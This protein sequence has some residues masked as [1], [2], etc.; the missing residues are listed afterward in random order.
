MEIAS[1]TPSASS[2]GWESDGEAEINPLPLVWEGKT[3][4]DIHNIFLEA[5]RQI[6]D[7]QTNNSEE[8]LNIAITGYEYLLGPIHEETVKVSFTLATFFVEQNR[9]PEAYKVIERSSRL[10]FEQLGIDHKRTQQH[11]MNVV[12][13][14]NGWN[15]NDDALAFLGRAKELAEGNDKPAGRKT[16]RRGQ[17]VPKQLAATQQTLLESAIRSVSNASNLDQLDYGLSIARTHASTKDEAVE[18][19]LLE[20]I[21]QSGLNIEKAALQ[22]IQAWAELL[23]VERTE[24]RSQ[25]NL[26]RF[27]YA[28]QAFKKVVDQFPW[29]Q[30]TREKFKSQKLIE[31]CLEL[32]ATFVK[33]DFLDDAR[34]IFQKCD[35][36]ATEAFGSDDERTIWMLIS[37]GLVYQKYKGWSAATQ[38]FE[39]ALA[40]AM[41]VYD[42]DDGVII[43]LEEAMEVKHFSYLNDEGRPYKT[44][45]GVGGLRIMPTRLHMV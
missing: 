39:Q 41:G 21:Y 14:L 29:N 16:G 35:E 42:K 24:N 5:Q 19:I 33:A 3:Q 44:I 38:W 6:R 22:H 25:Q 26:A 8:M 10:H 9:I 31:A 34:R 27:D 1:V 17:R 11:I 2:D 7:G 45:F 13:L 4:D 30:P 40:A 15:R 18:Q 32:G 12:E 36:K 23:D 28:L 37:I 20:T 43:S